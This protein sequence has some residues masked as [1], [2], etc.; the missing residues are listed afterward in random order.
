M[1]TPL[2]TPTGARFVRIGRALAR[3]VF[4]RRGDR[5][6]VHLREVELAALLALASARADRG[7]TPATPLV[8]LPSED[9]QQFEKLLLQLANTSRYAAARAAFK[10]GLQLG[11][12]RR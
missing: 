5:A 6:E 7:P 2:D 8:E 3:E 12:R 4:A 10:L 1:P 11:V 9:E